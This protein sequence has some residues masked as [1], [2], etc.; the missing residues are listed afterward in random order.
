MHPSTV[1]AGPSQSLRAVSAQL[2]ALRIKAA[3]SPLDL[4]LVSVKVGRFGLSFP[5]FILGFLLNGQWV[6]Q[7]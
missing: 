2:L 7:Q 6:C 3:I 1:I 5:N 4:K